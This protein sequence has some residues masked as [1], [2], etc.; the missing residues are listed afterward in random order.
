MAS[1]FSYPKKESN[2]DYVANQTYTKHFDIFLQQKNK[3]ADSKNLIDSELEKRTTFG[4]FYTQRLS[5]LNKKT[6]K[7]DEKDDDYS[8]GIYMYKM[9]YLLL[10]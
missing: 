5:G 2:F 3:N 7:Q 1:K 4:R 6:E 9:S 8:V 10:K